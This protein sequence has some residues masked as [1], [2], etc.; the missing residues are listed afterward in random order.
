MAEMDELDAL[1]ANTFLGEDEGPDDGEVI[2][3]AVAVVV[4]VI[5]LDDCIG[6]VVCEPELDVEEEEEEEKEEE[7]EVEDGIEALEAAIGG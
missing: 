6:F 1:E 3:F 7:E 5:G 2:T 4:V